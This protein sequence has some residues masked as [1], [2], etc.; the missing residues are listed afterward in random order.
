MLVS[1]NA[2]IISIPYEILCK[3][4]L[5]VAML[6]I[7][8]TLTCT[9]GVKISNKVN[10]Q[11]WVN[12]FRFIAKLMIV[13]VSLAASIFVFVITYLISVPCGVIFI[14]A[15]TTVAACAIGIHITDRANN[16]KWV[17]FFSF[18]SELIMVIS[19]L[20]LAVL[21]CITLLS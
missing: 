20:T 3:W 2:Y 10:N 7:V 11:K 16:Q 13:I 1:I 8:T 5:G 15:I 4:I 21:L 17:N 18:T 6:T 19:L 14:V 9:I 12:F